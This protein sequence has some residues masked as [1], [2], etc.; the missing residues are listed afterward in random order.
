MNSQNT[1]Y[2]EKDILQD[3]LSSQKFA[4]GNY[5]IWAG[6]C[7]NPQLRGAMLEILDDEHRIQNTIFTDMNAKGWYPVQSAEQQKVQQVRQK[8][9]QQP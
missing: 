3:C 1:Q 4:T 9:S 6:E 7:V 2:T 8:F 5:N